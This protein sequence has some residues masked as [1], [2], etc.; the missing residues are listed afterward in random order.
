MKLFLQPDVVITP[1][2]AGPILSRRGVHVKHRL[3]V[4]EAIVLNFLS[5]TGDLK[6]T[7]AGCCEC[8][9]EEEGLRWVK[10][11]LDRYWTYL[12]DGPARLLDFSWLEVLSRIEDDLP[13]TPHREAA[14][15]AIT[16]L[17]TLGCNRRCPYCYY[18]V[19]YHSMSCFDSPPDVTFPLPDVLRMVREMAQVGA[20]DLYLTGGEPLLRKDLLTIIQAASDVRVRTHLVTK[21]P[22]N[23]QLAEKLAEAKLYSATV[24]LDDARPKQA[25]T[26]SGT[27]GYLEEAKVAINSLLESGIWV[28]VNTVATSVNLYYLEPLIKLAV[29]LGVPKLTVSPY[30]VPHQR[31]AA[32]YLIPKT[33]NLWDVVKRLKQRY[34]HQIIL[35]IGSSAVS[36]TP[37]AEPRH[38][39]IVCEV[40]LRT[41]DV[42][43][44]GQVTRCHYLPSHTD[45][46]FGSLQRQT[47][48]EIWEST[49][50][51]AFYNPERSDFKDTTC[52]ECSFF[53]VC[54]ARGRCYF[55]SIMKTG[56]LY[57]PDVFCLKES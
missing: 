5:V 27:P 44:N 47:L 28:E 4:G 14:P 30:T 19:T 15:A 56:R 12:G 17:V 41:L 37:I 16:W 50:L 7:E 53:S 54:N 48:M 22:V 6:V 24:S 43:P 29:T 18:P 57:A 51:T 40:G 35:E 49:S 34:G 36:D 2:V 8:L 33:A 20:A 21:Y 55:S 3:K 1:D 46:V 39:R 13:Q 52:A 42:L 23:R 31:Q 10:R 32:A 26:L 45:L 11:V 9:G 25:A 38:E